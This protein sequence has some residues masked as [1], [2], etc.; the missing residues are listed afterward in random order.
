MHFK[1]QR[2]IIYAALILL[3]ILGAAMAVAFY[4]QSNGVTPRALAPYIERR[5]SGHNLLIV[6]AAALVGKTLMVLDRGQAEH[7][8]PQALI[9]GAQEDGPKVGTGLHEIVVSTSDEARKAISAA[10]PG[11]VISFL[12]GT[13]RFLG[14]SVVMSQAGSTSH[15]ITLRAAQAGTVF[16]EMNTTE[17]FLVTAPYWTVENLSIRGVC[18]EHANCE[19]AFHVTGDARYFSAIN[20]TITDFNAHFKV[21]G[22][23]GHY[24]DHGLIEAN[25]ISNTSARKTSNP[26]T[27]IDIV[28]ASDWHIR[29][30][31]ISDFVKDG[32]DGISYGAF[33]KG[34]GS[35]N[36]F[37]QNMILCERFLQ[38]LPGQR[39]G[40]SLG[41][42][43]TGKAYCRDGRCITEQ[44][45]SMI[46]SNLI[47]S[48]SDDGI[49]LNRAARS[50]IFHN[51]LVDTGGIT[52]RFPESS[53]DV[54]GNLV[55]G[56]IRSRDE[57]LLRVA[58]NRQTSIAQLYFGLHP[59]RDLFLAPGVLD[60]SWKESAPQ[61]PNVSSVAAELC[62]KPATTL[63]SYGAFEDFSSCLK[64]SPTLG[65]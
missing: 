46:R 35:N 22:V 57:G 58:D 31:L 61:R 42:G 63:A 16:I 45:D 24:P 25:T 5:S 53:A 8:Y 13:Y 56:A 48:C 17:G 19:H 52:V 39:V 32:G 33:A 55:D 50:K 2:L 30:N 49:Y 38:G 9:I 43:G 6:D 34:A 12:P 59:V 47:A 41:G 62:G 37:E 15:K 51:T 36:I 28:G 23:N 1:I 54:E 20:N 40:L 18:A 4:L 14:G 64:S 7:H 44:D 65:H 29:R 27:L 26:V 10:H 11:D 21:N 60:F 3:L